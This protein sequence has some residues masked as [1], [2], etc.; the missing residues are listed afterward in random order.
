MHA[1]TCARHVCTAL[2]RAQ[3]QGC[4]WCR[5]ISEEPVTNRPEEQGFFSI[6]LRAASGYLYGSPFSTLSDCNG[7]M[8]TRRY[9]GYSSPLSSFRIDRRLI[10]RSDPIAEVHSTRRRRY[11]SL[12]ISFARRFF[13]LIRS[14]SENVL[15]PPLSVRQRFHGGLSTRSPFPSSD[16]RNWSA[17]ARPSVESSTPQSCGFLSIIVPC[18][19]LQQREDAAVSLPS[20]QARYMKQVCMFLDGSTRE[21][22]PRSDRICGAGIEPRREIACNEPLSS[23]V[24]ASANETR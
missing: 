8:V 6:V 21:P 19:N 24:I 14:L 23:K 2:L 18:E 20:Q 3:D 1:L 4:T 16:A 9:Y 13:S 10:S 5:F 7:L 12:R 11:S 22:I 17:A 15:R